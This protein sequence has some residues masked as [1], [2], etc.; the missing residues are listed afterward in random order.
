MKYIE[1][2]SARLIEK[3]HQNPCIN[4]LGSI[5]LAAIY[6]AR[7]KAIQ[8][9]GKQLALAKTIQHNFWP[10]TYSTLTH[11]FRYIGIN[12]AVVY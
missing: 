1:K 6:S 9:I 11:S 3:L 8:R 4:K 10:K 5:G 2:L 7:W 12:G